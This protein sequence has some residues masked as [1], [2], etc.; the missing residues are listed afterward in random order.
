M[1]TMLDFTVA[2]R[3]FNG[4]KRLPLI[5]ERLRTQIQV[6]AIT[7]EV[8]VVDNNSNDDTAQVIQSYQ[9]NWEH[10]PLRYVFEP[11]QGASIAR[12]RAIKE[13]KGNLIGFLDDDNLP[14]ENW[15]AAAV[16]FGQATPQAGAFGSRIRGVFET[17]TPKN[18]ER[19]SQYLA[20]KETPQQYCY[21][22][23]EKG[24]PAGAGLV[25]RRQA[26]IESVPAH[27]VLQGP[28]GDQLPTKSEEIEALFHIRNT[29]WEIWHHPTMKIEH[30]IPE[31]RLERDYLLS[32]FRTL[33]LSRHRL[34]MLHFVPWQRPAMTI[35]YLFSDICKIAVF[36]VHNHKVLQIDVVAACEMQVLIGS[37][38]S[39][40]Y[41][42]KRTL[43]LINQPP[44]P[45]AKTQP[46]P[47]SIKLS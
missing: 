26:W 28:T 32:F 9:N 7:W 25:I 8:L 3:T 20:I 17:E 11:Q 6:E 14:S 19:I 33:G 40:F 12:R 18:F 34:R 37:L 44:H 30:Q 16:A 36:F 2:I 29:G 42:F 31:R 45:L 5:L 46:C 38:F 15:V 1:V 10:C 43:L 35:A 22:T 24:L 41:L 39:P 27:L 47:Q 21:D 13:A 4:A 23:Y